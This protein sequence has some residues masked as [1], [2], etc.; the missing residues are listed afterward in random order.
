MT[1]TPTEESTAPYENDQIISWDSTY[2]DIGKFYFNMSDTTNPGS[3]TPNTVVN[4]G[5]NLS[6]G[7]SQVLPGLS[8]IG[9]GL[10]SNYIPVA[11]TEYN[12]AHLYW[13]DKSGNQYRPLSYRINKDLKS[14]DELHHAG[15]VV[16]QGT[17]NDAPVYFSMSASSMAKNFTYDNNGNVTTGINWSGQYNG[18]TS[19]NF[20]QVSASG[21]PGTINL[22]YTG[23]GKIRYG[24]I[25]LDTQDAW[26]YQRKNTSGGPV[27]TLQFGPDST[28]SVTY[29]NM[30][31]GYGAQFR[32]VGGGGGNALKLDYATGAV[33]P[34]LPYFASKA[35]AQAAGW[36][37]DGLFRGPGDVVMAA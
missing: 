2:S 5:W 8:A 24:L 31:N 33:I 35:A 22:L 16:Y 25:D 26:I 12:E 32:T 30:L 23:F 29:F 28:A 17:P 4:F 9:I 15:L 11:G 27:D 19:N 13:V 10:E 21:G 1:D 3:S 7:G 18:P 20:V 36:P 6:P 37:A 34:K 14:A